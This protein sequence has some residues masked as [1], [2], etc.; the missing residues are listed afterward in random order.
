MDY[1]QARRI[2]PQLARLSREAESA[3]G[4]A[5]IVTPD[6]LLTVSVA[7]VLAAGALA[8]ATKG[9]AALIG[10]S[11]FAGLVALAASL[12][13][14]RGV[15][16]RLP[17]RRGPPR[18]RGAA[19]GARTSGTSAA[20]KRS[21]GARFCED[22][23][24]PKAGNASRR[25]RLADV[26]ASA[27]RLRAAVDF[28]TTRHAAPVPRQ[29]ECDVRVLIAPQEGRHPRRPD[30]HRRTRVITSCRLHFA[31]HHDLRAIIL[32][33]GHLCSGPAIIYLH[34]SCDLGGVSQWR[35]V[36]LLAFFTVIIFPSLSIP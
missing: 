11:L 3:R 9:G 8:A 13:R 35:H 10:P 22:V 33:P 20:R 14:R 17:A 12:P 21:S 23:L 15:L 25:R 28:D 2:D 36:L 16:G 1:Y 30:E 29:C 18:A 6:G 26:A 27:P 31:V 32:P 24:G 19:P 34:I 4:L 7:L 5:S